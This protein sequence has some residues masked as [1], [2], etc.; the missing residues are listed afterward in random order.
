M[1]NFGPLSCEYGGQTMWYS[2]RTRAPA[3]IGKESD[4][5]ER[6]SRPDDNDGEYSYH[7]CRHGWEPPKA[8]HDYKNVPVRR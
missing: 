3:I 8:R 5:S 1:P 4:I 2:L 6:A 7:D